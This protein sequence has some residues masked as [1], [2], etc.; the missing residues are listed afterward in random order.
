MAVSASLVLVSFF[1]LGLGLP[2]QEG[3]PARLL[4]CLT[5]DLLLRLRVELQPLRLKAKSLHLLQRKVMV[6]QNALGLLHL[7]LSLL[8][9]LIAIGFVDN[10]LDRGSTTKSHNAAKVNTTPILQSLCS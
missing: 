10:P 3:S 4:E 2:D 9:N 6:P 5:T 7:I 8:Q 1:L